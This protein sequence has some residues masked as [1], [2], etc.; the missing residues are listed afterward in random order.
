M[1]NKFKKA[2]TNE[3]ITT[4]AYY[5]LELPSLLPYVNRIIWLDGDTAV[6]EDLTELITIDMKNNY[7]M[8]FLDSL[9]D[10]IKRFD[11]NNATVLCSGV[12]LLDLNALRKNNMQKKMY[13]FIDDNLGKL[14]QHDQTVI[15]VVCQ[16]NTAPLPP[17][18]GIWSFEEKK[19]ALEFNERQRPW[20]KYDEEE[21]IKAYYHPAI[22]HYVYPKPFWKM[23][24]SVFN[25]EWWEYARISGFF[26]YIYNKSPKFK[27]NKSKKY[28]KYLYNRIIKVIDIFFVAFATILEVSYKII[29]KRNKLESLKSI[30]DI[31]IDN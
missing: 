18:Y 20:L 24:K 15:N 3:N 30:I 11:I 17:K 22:L 5:K 31:A 28:S 26:N 23:K 14:N 29:K 2:D 1:A 8:G 7:I 25:N 27:S 12:L 16:N 13:K 19:Y 10:A 4:S 6:F 21:F 9:P